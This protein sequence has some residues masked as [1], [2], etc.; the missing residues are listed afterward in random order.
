MAIIPK[1]SGGSNL[2]KKV[3]PSGSHIARCYG[4]IELG[5]VKSEYLGE[6]KHLHKVI[7]DFE[8]PMETAVF[9]D[10]EEEKPFVISKEYTLSFHEKSTLRA[11]LSSWRGKPFTD[12]EAAKFDI[13][14]L[15]GVPAMINVIHKASADGT[16]VYANIASISPMPKGLS[17]P[18]QVNDN[19][20]LS[21]SDWNQEVFMSLP[22]WL[23]D[24][25]SSTPEYKAKFSMNAPI[26]LDVVAEDSLEDSLPF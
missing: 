2:P 22:E 14:K 19:R 10:G 4:M 11:H 20:V 9:R 7:I 18:D 6:V 3:T 17:C 24:K 5:T 23:A 13:T 8:L 16:K 1:V 25:I 12:A 26:V 21:Y 15:V